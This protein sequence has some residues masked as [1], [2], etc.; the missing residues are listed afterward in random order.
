MLSAIQLVDDQPS[1]TNN[2]H[3]KHDLPSR[4]ASSAKAGIIA[5]SVVG[6]MALL[7]AFIAGAFFLRKRQRQKNDNSPVVDG[8]APPMLTPFVITQNMVSSGISGEQ[9]HRI[10]AKSAPPPGTA[11]GG[12]PPS[13]ARAA[14]NGS[15]EIIRMNTQTDSAASPEAQVASPGNPPGNR[16]EHVDME[17]SRGESS[18]SPV[19]IETDATRMAV[20]IES[21]IPLGAAVS[22]SNLLRT[23]RRED[24]PM[25]ELLR[26][27]NQRL[28]GRWNNPD[29]ELPPEYDEGHTT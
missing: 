6:G 3:A 22:P 23:E 24:I 2:H 27:L 19:A 12:E 13:S 14:V 18:T 25:E 10:Q 11:K 15:E 4:S 8:S 21:T 28:L 17:E 20:C 9:D 29:D 7:T 1:S 5:G 16:R 26:L